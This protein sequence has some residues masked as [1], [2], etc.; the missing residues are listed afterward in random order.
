MFLSFE[1]S[2]TQSYHSFRGDKIRTFR[3]LKIYWLG[4]KQ[5]TKTK[6]IGKRRIFWFE[7][8]SQITL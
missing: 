2:E 8:K 5:E 1:I 6:E 7:E 3:S 4:K